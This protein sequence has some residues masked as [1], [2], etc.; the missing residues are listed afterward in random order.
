[1]FRSP[2]PSPP[3]PLPN[4]SLGIHSFLSGNSMI[5]LD[6]AILLLRLCRM[7][8]LCTDYGWARCVCV[9][10]S[11]P[12]TLSKIVSKHCEKEL[13]PLESK[14]GRVFFLKVTIYFVHLFKTD[15]N[16]L[17]APLYPAPQIPLA[18]VLNEPLMIEPASLLIAWEWGLSSPAV[19]L[20]RRVKSKLLIVSDVSKTQLLCFYILKGRKAVG[21]CPALLTEVMGRSI[22]TAFCEHC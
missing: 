3:A 14:I 10:R 4:P 9:L 16:C 17:F 11:R 13:Q 20:W 22:S 7:P 1:M 18:C 12:K 19:L 5:F 21:N 2:T 15:C 6:K 8:Y